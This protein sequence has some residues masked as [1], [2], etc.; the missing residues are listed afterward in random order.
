[1]AIRILLFAVDEYAH[2]ERLYSEREREEGDVV[3]RTI[4]P[5][6]VA[7]LIA[8]LVGLILP[9]L[10]VG[11]YCLLAIYLVIPFKELTRIFFHR[12]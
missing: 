4:L 2:E 10:A 1:M 6:V 7:Y 8:T 5:V 11:L 3:R 9:G 12:S